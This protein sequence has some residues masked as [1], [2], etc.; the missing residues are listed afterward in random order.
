MRPTIDASAFLG[1]WPFRPSWLADAEALAGAL[2]DHGIA[3]CFVAP[4][5]ALLVDDPADA[6]DA[7]C[8]MVEPWEGLRPVAVWNPS[9]AN[10]GDVL[11][12]ALDAGAAAVKLA[13]GYHAYALDADDLAPS[14][15]ALERSGAA[16]CIQ[17]RVEDQRQARFAVPDAPIADAVALAERWRDIRWLLCGARTPEI[18]AIAERVAAAPNLW[19]DLSNADGLACLDR[20][21]ERLPAGRLLFA[22]HM[23]FF[24]PVANILKFAECDLGDAARR[25]ILTDNARELF[26]I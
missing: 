13:P 2:S 11:A 18:L 5:A 8:R 1:Q 4:A 17:L 24:Y 16:A 21:A 20:I 25:A 23:P 6:N 14:L 26:R 15:E 22:T 10:A 9:M 3:A 7:L 19:L 12:R